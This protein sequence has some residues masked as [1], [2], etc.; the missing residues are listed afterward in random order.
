MFIIYDLI[1]LVFALIYLPVLLFKRKLHRGYLVRLGL[2][3]RILPHRGSMPR[4][5]A[6]D[7]PIWIHAVSVGEA[8]AIKG[9]AEGLRRLYPQKGFVFSTV[10]PTG[11]KIV[12]K[13]AAKK[14]TVLYLPL[15]FSFIVRSVIGRINPGLFIIAETEIWPN[16]INCLSARRIPVII[17]NGRISDG[18]FR[19]YM[20]ARFLLKPLLNKIQLFCV[21]TPRDAGRLER[22]GVRG[23][24]IK[25]TGNIKFDLEIVAQGGASACRERLGMGR[26]G[27][28]FIAGST[29]PR[30]E[31]AILKVYRE[32]SESFPGL[33]LLIAPRHPERAQEI[34]NLIKKSGFTG[35][36]ISSLN[37]RTCGPADLRSVF[38]LDTIG[39]LVSFYAAADIVFVGGSLIKKGGH[40]I[41]EPAALGKPVIFGPHMFNFKDIRDLFLENQ[42]A[43]LAH[44]AS[45]LGSK[46]RR[47]LNTPEAGEELGRRAKDLIAQN[48]GATQRTIE[49]IR[50]YFSQQ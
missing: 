33:R 5:L 15:D 22:L 27:R 41:L 1:F 8:M 34:V 42:A 17:V 2:L 40:N 20:L 6:S 14:D 46:A 25:V 30:E 48:R 4:R 28:L 23:E 12:K 3:P 10:T 26:E 31:E 38:V 13:I 19:G 18:S 49:Y 37:L 35:V 47:L 43:L 11:N 45:D 44:N 21:Q 39:E 36:R 24:K 9:M 50:G 29:H 16:L 32:L 7:R